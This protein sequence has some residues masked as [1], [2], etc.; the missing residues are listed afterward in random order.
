MESEMHLGLVF[1]FFLAQAG[2]LDDALLTAARKGDLA[3]VQEAVKKGASLEAKTRYGVTPLYYAATGG[4][5]DVVRW[6]AEQ[7][8]DINVADTF[9]KAP[10]LVFAIQ[11]KHTEVALYLVGKGCKHAPAALQSAVN[12]GMTD[13]VEAIVAS[14][15]KPSPEQLGEAL[16]AAERR[17]QTAIV[18]V[19]RKAGAQDLPKPD[20]AVDPAVLAKYAGTY[21]SEQAGEVTLLVKDGKLFANPPGQTL[22]LGAFSPVSFQAVQVPAIKL[23][24]PATDG[25]APGFTLTQGQAKLEFKRVEGQ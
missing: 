15:V 22:E 1:A 11:R 14:P 8:A 4:H 19:L 6:L 21:R 18:G 10:A 13:L 23:A 12:A 24:F 20:F 2:E 7:G 25:K 9:Y 3:A 5:I 16:A 17:N